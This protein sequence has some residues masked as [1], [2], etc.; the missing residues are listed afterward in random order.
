MR[1]TRLILIVAVV[2][3]VTLPLAA[4]ANYG[5]NLS[6]YPNQIAFNC[7][8]HI[9]SF[10]ENGYTREEMKMSNET[11]KILEDGSIRMTATAV[12]V[13]VFRGHSESVNI[14]TGKKLPA[15]EVRAVL[16]AAPGVVVY[17]EPK[18]NIYPTAIDIVGKNETYGGRIREDESVAG[19]AGAVRFPSAAQ[20]RP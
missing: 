12:R 1:A 8:P 7:L 17:D 10:L 4:N 14:E 15:N 6:L 5:C 18:K 2:V 9:D 11:K 16:S 19:Y 3:A 13:P 20:P